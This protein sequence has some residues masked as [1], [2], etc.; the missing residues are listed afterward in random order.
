MRSIDVARLAGVS[1]SA[2]SRAFTPGAYI[3]EE[4]RAKVMRAAEMLDYSPNALARSLTQKHSRLIGLIAS[5][6]DNPFYARLLDALTLGLQGHGF[7]VLL[8]AAES[9]RID[10]LIPRLLSWRVDGVVLPA[11]TLSSRMAETLRRARCPVVLVN[12]R[13]DHEIA[14]S[15]TGDNYGGGHAVADLLTRTGCRRIAYMGGQ[16]DTSSSRDRELGLI[17]G[18][19]VHGMLVSARDEGHYTHEGGAAAARRLLALTPRP[20]AIFCANDV[21]AMAALE[22][23][24]VEFGLRVPEDLSIVGYDNAPPS[25]WPLH[26]LSTVDQDLDRMAALAVEMLLATMDRPKPEPRHVV[27]PATLVLRGTTRSSSE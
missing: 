20:D 5:S 18:L 4:T 10:G 1:R 3:A 24:R 2:V 13:L 21:M 17:A 27:V 23:A 26:N 8:L 15:V 25:G 19:A 11:A 16:R 7:G 14:S 6:L 12:R 9:A 22:V